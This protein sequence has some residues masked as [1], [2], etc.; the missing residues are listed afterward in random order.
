ME[1]RGRVRLLA[2]ITAAV[3]ATAVAAQI[4]VPVP[5]SP[6]PQSL[7]TLA[8][9]LSGTWLGAV[10]GAMALL[11]YV[12]LGA[13]GLPVFAGAAA[14]AATILGPSGGY[15]LGFVFGAVVSGALS[16]S[17]EGTV[18][19]QRV[20]P[21]GLAAHALILGTGWL[22]L[23]RLVG[24]AA[25]WQQGVAPFIWGGVAKSAVAAGVVAVVGRWRPGRR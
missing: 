12:L 8:V 14:G 22:G 9:V 18:R 21:A 15:L 24:T 1:R 23:T 19:W 4:D 5:G 3:L 25:A 10:G 6:V 17:A 7:Q 11:T 2:G 13:L 16:R 20:L